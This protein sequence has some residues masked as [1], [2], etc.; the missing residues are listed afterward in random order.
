MSVIKAN[1][2]VSPQELFTTA[3]TQGTDIGALATSG[4]GRYFRY[5]LNGAVTTVP[6]KVYQGPAQDA[7]NQSPAGGLAVAASAIGSTTVTLTGTLTLAANLLA[8]GFM[9]VAVTPGQ[10]YLYKVKSNTVVAAAANCV[11]TLEDPL[12]IA[13]TTASKVVFQQNPYNGTVVAPATLTAAPVGVPITAVTNAQNGWMQTHGPA[14]CLVTGTFAS[15]GLAVG[16]LV[17]GTIGSLAPAI[18]GTNVL[19]YTMGISATGE[20]DQ[21]FLTID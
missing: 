6:G 19:G 5:F 11:V 7:T 14:S 9:S 4:D 16:V 1:L 13:L 3:A 15:A 2:L 10:G 20:Y 8:Q 12:Q 17:G 21:V 18:A